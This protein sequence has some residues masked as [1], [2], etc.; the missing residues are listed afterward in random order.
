MAACAAKSAVVA[1]ARATLYQAALQVERNAIDHPWLHALGWPSVKM[2]ASQTASNY[3]SGSLQALT[4]E[5]CTE[6]TN[7]TSLAGFITDNAEKV[8]TNRLRCLQIASAHI[9]MVLDNTETAFLFWKNDVI[10]ETEWQ[11]WL[12]GCDLI[13]PHPLY[14]NVLKAGAYHPDFLTFMKRR[15]IEAPAPSDD[16]DTRMVVEAYWPELMQEVGR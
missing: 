11:I 4:G 9:S 13:S 8:N 16:V 10:E 15:L 5:S 6:L 3:F 12:N 1:Q 7:L 2:P 14:L